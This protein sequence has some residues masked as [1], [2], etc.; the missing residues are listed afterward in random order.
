MVGFRVVRC[1]DH[2]SAS[3]KKIEIPRP[4]P[5]H[6]RGEGERGVSGSSQNRRFTSA[7]RTGGS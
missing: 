3:V 2:G 1:G 6:F 4:P 5:D 7:R